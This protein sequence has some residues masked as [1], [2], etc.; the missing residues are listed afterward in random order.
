MSDLS[1]PPAS[2]EGERWLPVVGF[3]GLYEVSNLGRVRGLPRKTVRGVLGGYRECLAL[4][5]T[6][7]YLRAKLC[8]NGTAKRYLVHHLVTDAFLGPLPAGM[9]R[10]HLN[11]I[12]T[13][14][15]LVN[16]AFGSHTD[17]ACGAMRNRSLW[18]VRGNDHCQA[19]LTE[20]I[21]REIRRRYAVGGVTHADLATEYGVSQPSIHDAIVRKTWKHV[22]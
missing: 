22:A 17:N 20:D 9:V 8:R 19:K 2:Q 7:G 3:E 6:N 21:V 13:D 14:N 15:R 10:R 5:P 11:D 12:R 18:Q 16:L 4:F 1:T